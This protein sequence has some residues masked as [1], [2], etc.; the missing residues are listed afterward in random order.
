MT[1]LRDFLQRCQAES[2]TRVKHAQQF[3]YL[4]K[5][6]HHS[7]SEFCKHMSCFLLETYMLQSSV[8]YQDWSKPLTG[9]EHWFTESWYA[10]RGQ[11]E[12][13]SACNIEIESL[14]QSCTINRLLTDCVHTSFIVLYLLAAVLNLMMTSTICKFFLT[15]WLTQQLIY[16]TLILLFLLTSAHLFAGWQSP[17]LSLW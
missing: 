8:C 17:W 7:L 10:I 15:W 5:G 11:C 6:K 4:C 1:W 2:H 14:T 9:K 3:T 12:Q 13:E 16:S